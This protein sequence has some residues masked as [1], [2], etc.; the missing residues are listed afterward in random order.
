MSQAAPA[1]APV[2]QLRAYAYFRETGA[3]VGRL[4]HFFLVV[5]EHE[6]NLMVW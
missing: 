6:I 4:A 2:S 5:V 1:A 3:A